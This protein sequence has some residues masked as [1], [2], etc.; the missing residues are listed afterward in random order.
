MLLTKDHENRYISYL[1]EKQWEK[2][3]NGYFN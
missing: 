1:K 3:R 2:K